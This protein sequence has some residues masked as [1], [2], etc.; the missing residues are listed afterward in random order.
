M[1][2]IPSFQYHFTVEIING[3]GVL[4]I[5]E[6]KTYILHGTLYEEIAK[7]MDGHKTT[8]EISNLISNDKN[9][10]NIH[11]AFLMLEQKGF[12]CEA[13]NSLAKSISA[14]WATES[15]DGNIASKRL[16]KE[17]VWIHSIGTVSD[18][19]IKSAIS[20]EGIEFAD[21]REN[22]SLAVVITDDYLNPELEQFNIEALKSNLTWLLIRP[23]GKEILI[24]PWFISNSTACYQ[25]LLL[26][27]RRH[28]LVEEFVRRRRYG[29]NTGVATAIAA[30]PATQ[31]LAANL[32]AAE[33]AR[34]IG[35]NGSSRLI[36]KILS[37][38]TQQWLTQ[39]HIIGRLKNCRT[40]GNSTAPSAMPLPL[41]LKHKEKAPFFEDG[42]HR[43]VSPEATLDRYKHLISPITGVISALSIQHQGV[44]YVYTAGHNSAYDVENLSSLKRGLQNTN[45]GKGMT[46]IQAKV[47]ALC[48]AIER[49]SGEYTGAE[50]YVK[51]SLVDAPFVA[52]DPNLCMLY[53]DKQYQERDSW[54]AKNSRFNRVPERFNPNEEIN[55]TPAWSLTTEQFKYFP[56][57]YLYY[58]AP[59]VENIHRRV[60]PCCSN[61]NAAG[62]TIEEAIIQGLFELVERDCVALWWYNRLIKPGVDLASFN[63]QCFFELIEYYD[64]IGRDVWAIDITSDLKIPCFAAIS[65]QRIGNEEQILIGLGCHLD[66]HIAVQ[67]ALAEMNQMLDNGEMLESGKVNSMILDDTETENWLKHATLANQPYV[68]I[69]VSQPLKTKPEYTQLATGDAL[70]DIIVCREKI[71]C[72]G[73]EIFV[74]DQT[75]EDIGLPVVKVIIPGLRHFWARFA[76]G[77]L[78]DIPIKL[79]WLKAPLVEED[80]NPISIFF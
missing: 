12:I 7:V 25:C 64:S 43:T 11:Y 42:G 18:C 72:T 67:R 3:E 1:I 59:L 44:A 47:S 38:D 19:L 78:Y 17:K 62:N 76:P 39:H 74:L 73:L 63:D 27:L 40:C 34:F 53:S 46:E 8:I 45:S 61:G 57:Q 20:Q 52:I 65:R 56:T 66:A 48:E 22:A 15:L 58:G 4:L 24:G 55:W 80:S 16:S 37:L 33:V 69:D 13:N 77:R 70:Q 30:L 32:A 36:G 28:K 10:T 60:A 49:Y 54:N 31:C 14:F 26:K 50:Y 41:N 35:S 71:E 75:Q 29:D 51:C 79:G 23:L 6:D 5:S 68:G 2:K 9:A 21:G